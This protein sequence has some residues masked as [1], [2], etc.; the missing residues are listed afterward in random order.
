MIAAAAR[1]KLAPGAIFQFGGEI[2]YTPIGIHDGV[3]PAGS[4]LSPNTKARL[5]FERFR[6]AVLIA[7]ERV[8]R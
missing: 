8:Q 1:A 4:E 3:L 6:E 7:V 5:T 2:R